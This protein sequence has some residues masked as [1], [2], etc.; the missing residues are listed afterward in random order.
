ML[1]MQQINIQINLQVEECLLGLKCVVPLHYTLIIFNVGRINLYAR[2][3]VKL[4]TCLI[5]WP[6]W[7]WRNGNPANKKHE[8][9]AYVAQSLEFK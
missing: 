1:H 4:E 3:N 7:F 6:E 9:D 8:R 5:F 2:R